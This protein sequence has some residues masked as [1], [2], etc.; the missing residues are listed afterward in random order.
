MEV[1]KS[2]VMGVGALVLLLIVVGGV[3]AIVGA[4]TGHE[5]APRPAR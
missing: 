4:A 3:A 2:I 5:P 1:T